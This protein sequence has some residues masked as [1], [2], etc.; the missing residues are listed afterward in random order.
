MFK[1]DQKATCQQILVSI[2][3]TITKTKQEVKWLPDPLLFSLKY[4]VASCFNPKMQELSTQIQYFVQR[5]VICGKQTHFYQSREQGHPVLVF[6]EYFL[7][8]RH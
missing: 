5:L 6:R 8:K 2:S 4:L 1:I 7:E 3:L